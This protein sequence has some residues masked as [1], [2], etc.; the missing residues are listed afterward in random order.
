M[1][2]NTAAATTGRAE[3]ADVSNISTQRASQVVNR[4]TSGQPAAYQKN[5][6]E[7]KEDIP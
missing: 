7:I 3:I 5:T 4:F 2:N 6:E 1:N